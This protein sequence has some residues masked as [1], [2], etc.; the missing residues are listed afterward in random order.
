M[1]VS[2]KD[3][4][5]EHSAETTDLRCPQC[6]RAGAVIKLPDTAKGLRADGST[7]VCLVKLGCNTGLRMQTLQTAMFGAVGRR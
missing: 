2:W 7:H 6:H 3:K 1:I 5:G 4:D